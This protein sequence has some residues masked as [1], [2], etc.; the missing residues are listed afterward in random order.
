MSSH[1]WWK[2]FPLNF[3]ENNFIQL[4]KHS[5]SFRGTKNK[6]TE[7]KKGEEEEESLQKWILLS[8]YGQILSFL[9]CESQSS[10]KHP[11][12][13]LSNVI[14]YIILDFSSRAS[15]CSILTISLP[16]LVS[17]ELSC[18]QLFFFLVAYSFH[19]NWLSKIVF[20]ALPHASRSIL[21]STLGL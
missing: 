19:M 21:T 18:K 11:L 3:H 2:P 20:S 14:L 13:V 8:A 9:S 12:N 10:S 5:E 6:R 1:K 17:A 4:T 15:G 7:R 16:S